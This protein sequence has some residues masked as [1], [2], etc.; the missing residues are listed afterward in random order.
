V[1][2][3]VQVL[4]N[5]R[6]VMSIAPVKVPLTTDAARLPYWAEIPLDSLPAGQY[7]LLVS[8]TDRIGNASATQRIKF[9]VE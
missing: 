2:V 6:Q 5:R 3:H 4:R 9:S 8:A 7:V 1:W